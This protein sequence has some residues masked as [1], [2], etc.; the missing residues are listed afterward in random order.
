MRAPDPRALVPK[1]TDFTSRLRGPEVTSRVGLWLG[2][3]FLIASVTGL[4]SHFQQDMPGWLTL[5][6][7]LIHI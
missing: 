4:Y 1:P 5:P 7:S 3:C 6:L 2:I